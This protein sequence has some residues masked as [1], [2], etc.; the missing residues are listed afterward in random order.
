MLALAT[1]PP[2]LVFL[3]ILITNGAPGWIFGVVLLS[4]PAAIATAVLHHGLYDLRRA[5]HRALLWR[6]CRPLSSASTRR[7]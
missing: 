7:W 1:A 6:P 2:A 5:A 3:S 4:L